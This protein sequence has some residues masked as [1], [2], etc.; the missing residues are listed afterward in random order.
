MAK[1][2]PSIA[3]DAGSIPGQG[4]KISHALWPKKPKHRLKQ[5]CNKFNKEERM[6]PS[7][8]ILKKGITS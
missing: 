6:V 4:A 5:H 3:G 7:K 1:T 2:P 8:S